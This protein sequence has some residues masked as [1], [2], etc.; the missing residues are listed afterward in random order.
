MKKILLAVIT[1]IM[2]A[3]AVS[4]QQYMYVWMKDG[5]HQSYLISELDSV[6]FYL[7][8]NIGGNTG[9]IG[10]FSVSATEKVQFAPGNLQYQASTD[11]WRFA[12]HQYDYIGDANKNISSTYSGWI[13]LFGWGT[14]NAPT[15][16]STSDS[17]YGTFIDWGQNTISNGGNDA[18]LWRT[19]SREEW[20]YLFHGRTN[21]DKLFGLG[22]VAGV[23]GVIILPDNWDETKPQG[24][25]FQPS[26]ANG[27]TWKSTYYLCRR[28]DR[29]TD[30]TYSA[31]QWDD[32]MQSAGAVFL[33]ASG[34]RYG[35]E[36]LYTDSY[37]RYWSSTQD[38]SNNA[39][40]LNISTEYLYVQINNGR[41][42][43]QS[44]R[45]VRVLM[46]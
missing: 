10:V 27:L 21:Y 31:K 13:D 43:G 23:N 7:P 17:D 35:N 42:H 25:S 46:N 6:G 30:N 3:G 36:V 2:T 12:E 15:K 9:G 22:N 37:C 4:A 40:Y 5:T 8:E 18:G 41:A 24:L 16:S 32:L 11:T 28:C 19:L 29:Y 45:L 44:V 1:L 14:G 33:S 39:N 20:E 26:V 34:D 38:G